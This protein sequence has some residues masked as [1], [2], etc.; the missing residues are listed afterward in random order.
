[1]YQFIVKPVLDFLF[2]LIGFIVLLPIFILVTI[3]LAFAN[4]GKAFFLQSRPGLN[5]KIFKIIKFKTM[6]DK[7][8]NN[9]NFLSDEN[10]LTKIGKIV[11]KTSL[12]EIPQLLNVIMGEMSLVGPRPLLVSY[13]DFYSDIQ[14]T[15]HNVKPGITGWAQINGR[16]TINWNQKFELDVWYVNNIS[17]AVDFKILLR[18][19]AKLF[20]TA[21]ITADGHATMP[22]FDQN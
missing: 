3:L 11:R 16:N 7:K 20:A 21:D 9:G 14:A 17:A 18:T 22:R 8:D 10:R 12:D 4:N 15:R 6:N 5:S 1:M 19:I 2:S 13:L